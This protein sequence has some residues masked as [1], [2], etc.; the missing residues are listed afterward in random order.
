MKT[1]TK[2]AI[3]EFEAVGQPRTETTDIHRSSSWWIMSILNIPFFD[4]SALFPF[5]QRANERLNGWNN[6]PIVM[7][8]EMDM[9][10]AWIRQLRSSLMSMSFSRPRP[11]P[12]PRIVDEILLRSCSIQRARPPADRPCIFAHNE[13]SLSVV[14]I[15]A[16]AR[17]NWRIQR[18]KKKEPQHIL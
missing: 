13:H 2:S 17:T 4:I 3:F 18:E 9:V 6:G 11:R 8:A 5:K 1:D 16:R 15:H 12:R 14:S 7:C 10:Y